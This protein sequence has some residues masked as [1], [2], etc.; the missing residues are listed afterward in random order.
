MFSKVWDATVVTG[1]WITFGL[2]SYL[3]FREGLSDT[4][5]DAT[6]LFMVLSCCQSIRALEKKQES[7]AS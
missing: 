7:Q 1:V 4:W 2:S 6:I 5:R 3:L